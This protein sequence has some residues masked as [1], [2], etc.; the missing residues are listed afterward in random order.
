MESREKALGKW[1]ERRTCWKIPK[2]RRYHRRHHRDDERE[3]EAGEDELLL[4]R[5]RKRRSD[6]RVEAGTWDDDER[7]AV[8]EEA[9]ERGRGG[10]EGIGNSRKA[11]RKC[12]KARVTPAEAPEED[13]EEAGRAYLVA[14]GSPFSRET[15]LCFPSWLFQG[16]KRTGTRTSDP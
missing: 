16:M 9:A 11:S 6:E 4:R 15:A 7:A 8:V 12:W 3:V 5:Q 14:A 1:E 10:E 2:S 13:V